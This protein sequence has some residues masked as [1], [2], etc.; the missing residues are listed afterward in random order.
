MKILLYG[1]PAAVTERAAVRY[2]FRPAASLDDEGGEAGILLPVGPVR[3]PAEL[4]SLYNTM[5]AR[6]AEIDAVV[7]CGAEN[8]DACNT[9]RYCSP[10]GK[11]YTLSGDAGDEMLEYE[12]G[13]I[14]ETCL[15][16]VCAHEGV[17]PVG[18]GERAEPAHSAD[19][20]L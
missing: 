7:V 14:V 20:N 19:S 3:T 5:L 6:E 16:L 12:L 10:P 18:A 9:V 11:F 15:G 2:G 17:R 1:I 13:R 4:L 8:C